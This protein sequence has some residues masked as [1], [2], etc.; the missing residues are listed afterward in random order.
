MAEGGKD[1]PSLLSFA[2][3]MLSIHAPIT[4]QRAPAYEGRM[5][6]FAVL[7]VETTSGD[8]REGHLIE[9]AVL[10]LDGGI[11]RSIWETLIAPPEPVPPFGDPR[12]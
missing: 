10:A 2:L 9:V 12:N 6:R 5:E 11:H 7:D 8:P 1:R 4:R 3:P